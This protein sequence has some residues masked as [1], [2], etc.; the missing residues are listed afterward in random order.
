MKNKSLRK[1]VY[2]SII[3]AIAAILSYFDKMLSSVIFPIIPI[4]GPYIAN[5]KIGF[6]NLCILY[7]MYRFNFKESFIAVILKSIII[8][9]IYSSFISFLI[10]FIGTIISFLIM[11]IIKKDENKKTSIIVT[12]IMGGVFHMIG[13]LIVVFIYYGLEMLPHSVLLYMP[14][15]LLIGAITGLIIGFIYY[16]FISKL[17]NY[18]KED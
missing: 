9:F 17:P 13:Q 10:G 18:I 14:I 8:G 11:W 1:I 16:L 2:L 3:I 6:A 5:I 4:I 7:I 15:T 12:S